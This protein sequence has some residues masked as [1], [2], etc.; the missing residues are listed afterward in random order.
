MYFGEVETRS[1]ERKACLHQVFR[2]RM[3]VIFGSYFFS[4]SGKNNLSGGDNWWCSDEPRKIWNV[5]IK[6][7]RKVTNRSGTSEENLDFP[8]KTL[9]ITFIIIVVDFELSFLITLFSKTKS[10]LVYFSALP[11]KLYKFVHDLSAYDRTTKMRQ[12]RGRIRKTSNILSGRNF[13]ILDL[14][15]IL[16]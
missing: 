8:H 14:L 1:W 9:F 3:L 16:F 2:S 4:T 6:N 10:S 12:K 11:P 5:R 15:S 7:V 13:L